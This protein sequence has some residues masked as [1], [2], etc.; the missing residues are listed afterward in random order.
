MTDKSIDCSLCVGVCIDGAAAM[1]GK[2]SGLVTDQDKAPNAV[3]THCMLHHEALVAKRIDD[4]LHQVLRYV[5]K[6]VN[7]VNAHPLKHRLFS[8]LWALIT[9]VCRS[10]QRYA[11]FPAGNC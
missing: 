2:R 9:R 7:Y 5:V 4:D 3:A 10:T 1:T 11:G 8:V 6:T